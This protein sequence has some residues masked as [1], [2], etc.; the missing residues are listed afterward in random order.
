MEDRFWGGG[1]GSHQRGKDKLERVITWLAWF[2]YSDRKTLAA[3]LSV[4][5]RGQGAF[6]RRLEQSG[7]LDVERAP[8]LRHNIYSLGSAGFDLARILVPDIDLRRRRRLPAWIT[9]VHSFSTQ[10]AVIRRMSDVA[11]ILPEK[12]LK[13]L[14]AVRLPDVVL[15]MKGGER[16]ALEVELHHKSTAR[17]YHVFLAHLRNIRN[18]HYAKVLYLFPN[19]TLA[20]LYSEKFNESTWPIFRLSESKRLM[21][22][23]S[24]SFDASRVHEAGLFSFQTEELYTL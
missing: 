23:N 4:E 22:D 20:R 2:D 6:F 21:F 12:T 19:E 13:T 5:E 24:K 18:G 9:L 14:R 17:V 8:A 16:V 10:V 15:G 7:F 1:A 3:M 11:R